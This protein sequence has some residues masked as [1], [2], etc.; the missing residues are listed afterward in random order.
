MKVLLIIFL[1]L[2]CLTALLLFPIN[3]K[4]H[5]DGEVRG[6]LKYLF[7]KINIPTKKRKSTKKSNKLKKRDVSDKP[8]NIAKRKQKRKLSYYIDEYKTPVINILKQFGFLLKK[9]IV[10]EL[11]VDIS[12]GDQDASKAAIEYGLICA[13]LYPLLSAFENYFEV[14]ARNYNISVDY[15]ADNTKAN[16]VIDLRLRPLYALATLTALVH[17]FIKLKLKK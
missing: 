2:L 9:I 8:K 14:K 11:Y 10:K 17:I 15:N 3:L 6:V 16:A 1:I 13:F 4:L 5:F 7:F 12:V